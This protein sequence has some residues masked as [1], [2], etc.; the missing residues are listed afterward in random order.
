MATSYLQV[1]MDQSGNAAYVLALDMNT[2]YLNDPGQL[3]MK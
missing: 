1:R 2:P 3:I